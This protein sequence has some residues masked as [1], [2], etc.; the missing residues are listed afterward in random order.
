MLDYLPHINANMFLV[1]CPDIHLF[2]W[3]H[4]CVRS[5]PVP[6]HDLNPET[7]D[8]TMLT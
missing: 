3:R 6:L 8:C 1:V 7:C 2:F 4:L 5:A